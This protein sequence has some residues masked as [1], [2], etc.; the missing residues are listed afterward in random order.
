MKFTGNQ[1]L[2]KERPPSQAVALSSGLNLVPEIQT[3]KCTKNHENRAVR[4]R[5]R[6]IHQ[7]RA[8]M[9]TIASAL[10]LFMTLVVSHFPLK[11]NRISV[12]VRDD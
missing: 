11:A 9:A 7:V 2:E 12:I 10:V 4:K 5:F 6:L 3:T 8:K 1:L